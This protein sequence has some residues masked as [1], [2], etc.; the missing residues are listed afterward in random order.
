MKIQILP[1]EVHSRTIV[2]RKT[3]QQMT[4]RSQTG[5]LKL[6]KY[7][8][9]EIDV[10]LDRDQAGYAPGEYLIADA[11]FTVDNFK[12]VGLGRLVLQPVVAAANSQAASPVSK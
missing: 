12:K 1:G 11:S 4:F 2:S 10:S 5:L 9:R 7:E 6:G 8:V 3:G